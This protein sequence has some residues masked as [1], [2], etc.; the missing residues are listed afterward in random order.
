MGILTILFM[1][2][3]LSYED[4]KGKNYLCFNIHLLLSK[5]ENILPKIIKFEKFR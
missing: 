1:L 3:T 5:K 2:N 4:W